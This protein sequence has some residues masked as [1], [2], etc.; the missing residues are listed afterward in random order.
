MK[1]QVVGFVFNETESAVLLMLKARPEWQVGRLNGIGGSIEPGETPSQAML[2]EVLEEVPALD[3]IPMRWHLFAR[4][5]VRVQDP[6]VSLLYCFRSNASLYDLHCTSPG[7]S[8]VVASPYNLP[9]NVLPNLHWLIPMAT[10]KQRA[11]WPFALRESD[12]ALETEATKIFFPVV[13]KVQR[14]VK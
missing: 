5:S 3:K 12:L 2:R 1:K 13:R 11:D 4:L 14:R 9:L 8:L 10:I 6:E 7:E